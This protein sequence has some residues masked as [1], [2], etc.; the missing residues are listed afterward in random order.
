MN[1]T[2]MLLC[3]Y[4]LFH[5]FLHYFKI[6]VYFFCFHV[7][8]FKII[9]PF[10]RLLFGS[11]CMWIQKSQTLFILKASNSMLLKSVLFFKPFEFE[12]FNI[13][14]FPIN[15]FLMFYSLLVKTPDNGEDWCEDFSGRPTM[16]K[17]H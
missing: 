3:S 5:C 4:S 11:F 7:N 1:H 10:Q 6:N 14:C 16:A 2:I 13:V 17:V 12:G 8:K 9:N 15:L